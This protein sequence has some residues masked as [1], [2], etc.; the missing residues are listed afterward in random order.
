M[1]VTASQQKLI[2]E[3]G[4][5]LH[6]EARVEAVWLAGSLGR[7]QGDIFS[8]VDLLVLV[9]DGTLAEVSSALV[10]RFSTVVCAVH[11]NKLFG[12]R[13]L[14]VVTA[15][16]QRFDLSFIQREDLARHNGALLRSLFNKSGQTPPEEPEMPYR[17]APEQLLKLVQEFIRVL[18]LAVVVV[19]RE[20]YAVAL[21]G[22]EHLRRMT[23]DLMMEENRVAPGRR[24]GALHRNS[25]LNAEQRAQLESLSP[26]VAERASVIEGHRAFAEVFLPRARRL[27][28]EIGMVWPSDFEEAT[29]RYLETKLQL[30]I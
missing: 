9:E 3:I 23:F 2:D 18:G 6:E 26:L 10:A 27:A 29:R 11:V 20:E 8:D 16:W 12:G 28:A 1:M 25:L 21:S 15:D 19:G 13:V 30:R 22:I 4:K 14:N 5:L 7:G 24:G 17:P